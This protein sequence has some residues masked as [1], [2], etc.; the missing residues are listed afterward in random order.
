MTEPHPQQPRPRQISTVLVAN[1]GEIARRVIRAC[2]H[3]GLRSVAIHTDLDESSLH[4]AEADDAVRVGSYLDVEEVVAATVSAGADAVHPGYGFLSENAA[5]ARAVEA[6]GLVFVGPSPDVIELM[7]RKDRAREVAEGAGVPVTPR[8]ETDDVP[9]D[10][11]PVLVKAAAGGGGKGMHVVRRPED[12]ADAVATARREA[13]SSFGDD[14]LLVEAYVEGGRHVEVQVFGDRHGAVVHLFERDCSAQRRH[15]KVVEEA[16]APNLDPQLRALLHASSVALCE[17]VGYVGAGTVEFLVAEGPDG[18]SPAGV[19]GDGRRDQYAYFLEMNTRLQVEHPVTEQVTGLDLVQW[20]LD[21]AAGLPL[22]STQDEITCTGHAVEVRVYAEDPYTGFLPQA[23]HVLDARWGGVQGQQVHAAIEGE[24]VVS[25]SYDPMLAKLVGTGSDRDEA[26]ASVLATIDDSAVEGIATNL[27]WVRRLV[28]SDAFRAGE[29][30]TGWLDAYEGPLLERPTVADEALQAAAVLLDDPG[31]AS[32]FG[33]SDGWRP[34]GASAPRAVRVTEVDGT[35]HVVDV[36]G[37][38]ALADATRRGRRAW[39]TWQG[40]TWVLETADAMRRSSVAA[41]GD[42]DVVAP[43]PGSVVALDVAVGDAVTA[44]QRLGAVEAMKMELALVAPHDGTVTHV[45]AAV[46]DQV[47][48]G[49][50]VV[51]VD[52]G[53]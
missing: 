52:E 50:V 49:H 5:F 47:A 8:Y 45:G 2:S 7:G 41:A 53:A 3:A 23:G 11:Y 33:R 31:D 4:V 13:A 35:T 22:P 36:G 21:V 48:M 26:I 28:D 42:A 1:R 39:A 30:H 37:G 46:G 9:A 19:P 6:A 15:Q 25:S 44:G 32:P 24:A 40:Q 10:A 14:T 17:E 29:V 51:H 34:A 16:P 38:T 43:M 20:Q 12:L 27:G 18:S